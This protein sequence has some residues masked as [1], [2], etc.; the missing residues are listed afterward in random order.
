MMPPPKVNGKITHP[1]A[2][3][4]N[5]NSPIRAARIPIMQSVLRPV[6]VGCPIKERARRQ[7]AKE[8]PNLSLCASHLPKAYSR[9]GC[10]NMR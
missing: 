10:E 7:L 1:A 9:P 8:K 3:N 6:G 4:K 5:R 2:D